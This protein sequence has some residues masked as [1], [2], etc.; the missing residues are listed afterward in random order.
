MILRGKSSTGGNKDLH[1]LT[2]PV[3]YPRVPSGSGVL[4]EYT[5]KRFECA[6]IIFLYGTKLGTRLGIFSFG[7]L[8]TV[9]DFH[10]LHIY[11]F[12]VVQPVHPVAVANN[13]YHIPFKTVAPSFCGTHSG[14]AYATRQV[15][16]VY[17]VSAIAGLFRMAGNSNPGPVN[18]GEV[19]H[20]LC[21]LLYCCVV[22]AEPTV[23]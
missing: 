13:G 7:I 9:H 19:L 12:H 6:V 16:L 5:V 22:I 23:R 21:K 4:G 8:W 20:K 11:L 1:I 15:Q 3:H 14:R 2:H 17:Q 10:K 18:K